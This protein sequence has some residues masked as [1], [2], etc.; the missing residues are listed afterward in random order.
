MCAC[1]LFA[2]ACVGR[3][4]QRP[5]P[6]VDSPRSVVAWEPVTTLPGDARLA[7]HVAGER[8]VDA[9]GTPVRL[10]G[11]AFG[12]EVWIDRALPITHHDERDYARVAAMRMNLVRFYLNHVTLEDE[13]RP[14]HFRA[15]G[16]DWLDRNVR[17]AAAHKVYLLFNMHVPP[18]GYQ[19]QGKGGALWSDPTAADR[20][21]ALWSALA[22]RYR[23]QPFVLGYDLL[24]EPVVTQSRQQWE[25]LARRT[26][27]A[28]RAVDPH[29]IIVVE[30]T[31][32]VGKNWDRDANQNFFLIDDPNTV[33]EF[34][35]YE[36][37]T[38]THQFASW[39]GL[40]EGGRYPDPNRIEG[41]GLLRW[42]TATFDAPKARLEPTWS[43][44]EGKPFE[45]RDASL[46]T[47]KPALV[48]AHTAGGSC[49]YDDLV[50]TEWL[51]GQAQGRTVARVDL[52]RPG[53]WWLWSQNGSGQVGRV[54]QGH[55]DD[56]ALVIT[57]TTS[58]AN[59]SSDAHRFPVRLGARYGV[60]GWMRTEGLAPRAV[61]QIRLDF[62]SAEGPVPV[63]DRAY[64][65]A[66]LD[67][68]V[69]WGRAHHV[70]LF[71]GEFGL[72]RP[73]FAGG[74]GGLAWVADMLDLLEERELP[75]T[76]HA[77]HE[78]AFGIYAGGSGLPDDRAVN[79][80]LVDLF[81]RRLR[82]R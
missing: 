66:V 32:A 57:G 37:F 52:S 12:N 4:V 61:C 27:R 63:R 78:D 72:M 80:P 7:L 3:P 67:S 13:S 16:W 2:S 79:Q 73:A 47:G 21:V 82:G 51:P 69:S 53:G 56:G 29:H 65:A 23:E 31:N 62:E 49:V 70:P 30:R 11:V 75:F 46:K 58:D 24:N 35:F 81:T 10:R 5:K 45:V 8:I 68:Y 38:F 25:T 33:Y 74:R 50:I 14:G 64:L 44:Y 54:G 26:A 55:D 60:A 1:V 48:G 22:T 15:E 39:V 77:Y 76:Y 9:S 71:L 19:S 18:G 6:P 28:V 59:A 36:P 20:F 42:R 34:H 40:G 43:L 41:G 17:W